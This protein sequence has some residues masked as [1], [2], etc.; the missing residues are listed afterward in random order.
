MDRKA[1][2]AL[3]ALMAGCA[4]AMALA[5][6]RDHVHRIHFDL[7]VHQRAWYAGFSAFALEAIS[8]APPR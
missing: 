8:P 4:V 6:R 3:P 2:Y 7:R 1:A 5:P